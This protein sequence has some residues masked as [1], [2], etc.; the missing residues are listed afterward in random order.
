MN[1]SLDFEM[2]DM[3]SNVCSKMYYLFFVGHWCHSG[4]PNLKIIDINN[5][6]IYLLFT[7]FLRCTFIIRISTGLTTL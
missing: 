6:M 3:V 2:T 5:V 4:V 1:I 7:Y